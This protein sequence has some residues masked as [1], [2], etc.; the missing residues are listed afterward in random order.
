MT[1]NSPREF[2]LIENPL[3]GVYIV[4]ADTYPGK[5]SYEAGTTL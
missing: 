5:I 4:N 1:N 2:W 3:N